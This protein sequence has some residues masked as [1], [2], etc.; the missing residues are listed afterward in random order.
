[1]AYITKAV[2][3]R[4][5]KRYQW[6]NPMQHEKR[7]IQWNLSIT[8]GLNNSIGPIARNCPKW[9]PGNHICGPKLPAKL[10]FKKFGQQTFSCVHQLLTQCAP[11]ALLILRDVVQSDCYLVLN[12]L[13]FMISMILSPLH[14]IWLY[15]QLI[16]EPDINHQWHNANKTAVSRMVQQIYYRTSVSRVL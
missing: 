15:D 8:A 9:P 4:L 14:L 5:A 3:P 11:Y 16:I 2:K 7:E 1:M 12:Q 10:A 13:L 6:G